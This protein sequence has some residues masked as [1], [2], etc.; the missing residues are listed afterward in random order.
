MD[1]ATIK[2]FFEYG[3]FVA[4]FIVLF[5]YEI[6]MTEKRELKYQDTIK[7]LGETISITVCDSNRVAKQVDA[8]CNT[9]FTNLRAIDSELKVVK[10]HVVDIKSTADD[11]QLTLAKGK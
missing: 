3:A 1:F 11:I 5:V 9:I 4:L 2:S 6:R 10:E 7:Q 8:T